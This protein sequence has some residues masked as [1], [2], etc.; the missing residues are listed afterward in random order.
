MSSWANRH[1]IPKRNILQI[2]EEL[3]PQIVPRFQRSEIVESEKYQF[4]EERNLILND[5]YQVDLN[6]GNRNLNKNNAAA[7]NTAINTRPSNLK[8]IDPMPGNSAVELKYDNKSY[9]FVILRNLRDVL[10]NNL[11]ISSYNSIRKLY[12]NKII[13]ID[14]NSSINTVNGNLFNTEVIYSEFNGAGEILPYY[15]FLQNKWADRMIF[16]HDSMFLYRSFNNSELDGLVKFHW[17]FNKTGTDDL[18][19][20][21]TYVGLLKNNTDIKQFL[22]STSVW[23]GCF[24]ATTIIDFDIVKQLDEKYAL[25]SN[26]IMYI[27]ARKDREIFERIFGIVLYYEKIVS[28]DNLSNFGDI[29]HY[30]GAFQSINYETAI[31]VI[32]QNNY[33]TAIIKVW[34]GR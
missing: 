6:T 12:T 24:G 28:D 23:N 2:P 9:V 1:I 3:R 16:I 7:T 27:R 32:Q 15:Y 13:I 4:Q 19:K 8:K 31:K 26:L 11:W 20:I 33:D 21:N 29:M 10:D 30:P 14:D 25:F 34:K 17:Y 5:T 22:E 18:K